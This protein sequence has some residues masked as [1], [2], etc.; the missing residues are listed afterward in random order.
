MF[1]AISV[2]IHLRKQSNFAPARIG[3]FVRPDKQELH[4][5]LGRE[6]TLAEFDAQWL[7][8]VKS[9]PTETVHVKHVVREVPDNAEASYEAKIQALQNGVN[10]FTDLCNE[11]LAIRDARIA[12]LEA[13]LNNFRAGPTVGDSS[14]ETSPLP[15][16]SPAAGDP[17]AET[18]EAVPETEAKPTPAAN[19]KKK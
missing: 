16:S 2:I 14:G 13:E 1:Q 10:E 11:Q 15:E 6:M 5:W 12:A 7:K 19:K 17:P 4:M 8:A 9:I 18:A 3:Q